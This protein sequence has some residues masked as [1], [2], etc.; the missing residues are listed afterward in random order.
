MEFRAWQTRVV[1]QLDRLVDRKAPELGGKK[2]VLERL[3]LRDN[4][5]SELRRIC[6][7]PKGRI[8]IDRV[9]R[10]INHL[11]ENPVELLY[12]A[13]RDLDDSMPRLARSLATTE[14]LEDDSVAHTLLAVRS[15]KA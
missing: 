5:L 9:F 12:R 7:G 4:F 10:L 15:R 14:D 8:P 1:A 3:G 6:Q 13:G 11:G 2:V